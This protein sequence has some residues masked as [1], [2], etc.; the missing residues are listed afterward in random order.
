MTRTRRRPSGSRRWWPG[1]SPARAAALLGLVAAL[2]AGYGLST[3][4]AFAVHRIEVSPLRWTDETE[5]VRWLGVDEGVN[6]FRLSTAGLAERLEGLPEV[7]GASVSVALPDTL[8]VAV[9]ERTPILAWRVADV[10]FLVDREGML[11]KW[12]AKGSELAAGLPTIVDARAISRVIL[13]VGSRLD[14]VDLDAAT[15]LASLVPDDVG[16]GA[17]SLAVRIT[18]ADGFVVTTSPASWAAVFGSY[19]KVLR[20]P[21]L[22]PGQ[23]RLLR[24][25][26]FGRDTRL[27]RIVLAD[28]RNGTYLPLASGG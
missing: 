1:P 7:L 2:L 15:R 27:A 11:F 12:L 8:V 26:L 22:I 13:G 25:L 19:G 21:E 14:P 10:T 24:S 28:D 9:T 6:A 5:L 3:A 4:Q 20:P 23:V 16:S 17:T 18:D